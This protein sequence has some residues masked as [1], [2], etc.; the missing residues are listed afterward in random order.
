MLI[1]D[2]SRVRAKAV[3]HAALSGDYRMAVIAA[4]SRLRFGVRRL[5]RRSLGAALDEPFLALRRLGR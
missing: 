3:Q 2:F 5:A 4:Q 1:L